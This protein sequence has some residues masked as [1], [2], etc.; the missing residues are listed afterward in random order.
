MEK[1]TETTIGFRVI[2]FPS[3]PLMIRV[4]LFLLFSFK[5]ET[6]KKG[7][8]VLLGS[9]FLKTSRTSMLGLTSR[10]QDLGLNA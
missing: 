2:R 5:K 4:S 10:S 9:Q 7:N 6:P 3:N 8:R 1:K